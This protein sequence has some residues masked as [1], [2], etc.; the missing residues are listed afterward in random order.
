MS[1]TASPSTSAT[2][3]I[4]MLEQM[5]A[6]LPDFSLKL[7]SVRDAFLAALVELD[8]T[9]RDVALMSDGEFIDPAHVR[10]LIAVRAA[11]KAGRLTEAL[12][13]LDRALD[14]ACDTWR[15]DA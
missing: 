12:D 5:E 7:R 9:K 6:A 2:D 10:R 14:D 3:P 1:H 8:G 15:C 13:E 11:M 4:Q